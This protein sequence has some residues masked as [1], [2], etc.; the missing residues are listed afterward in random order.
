M[1]IS[2]PPEMAPERM[3][4]P[5]CCFLALSLRGGPIVDMSCYAVDSS[6]CTAKQGMC[7][8]EGALQVKPGN[9]ASVDQAVLGLC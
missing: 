8:S 4:L 2:I 6:N 9:R 3:A 5:G 7:A 1:Q